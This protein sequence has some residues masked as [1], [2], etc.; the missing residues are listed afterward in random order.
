MFTHVTKV[1]RLNHLHR[2]AFPLTFIF[3]EIV[4]NLADDVTWLVITYVYVCE[5]ET[6]S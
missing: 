1:H 2:L 4:A 5:Q 3:P 6:A